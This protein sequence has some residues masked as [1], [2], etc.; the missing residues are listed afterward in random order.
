MLSD[1]VKM[2]ARRAPNRALLRADGLSDEDFKK[3]FIA[4]ANSYNNI[5]PGHI[6][7]NEL[8]EQ[9]KK[10]IKDAGGYPFEYGVPGICDGIIMGHGGM[11]YSLASRET[12]ADC[13][14]LMTHAHCF[15]GWVGVT[16][17]DKITPAMLMAAARINIPTIILTG[18]PM[19]AGTLD[20]KQYDLIS[21]FE[22]VGQYSL[23]K[24]KEHE[25]IQIEKNCCPG[26]GSCAGLFTANTMA[27]M[28]EALGMSITGSATTLAISEKKKEQ[29]YETGRQIVKL[30][31]ENLTPGDIMT[32]DAF[33]NAIIV[34]MAIGGSTNT[35]L[36]LPSIAKELNINL[37]LDTFNRIA[38]TTPNICS[39]RPGGSY[40]MK[41]LDTAG[42]IPAVLNRLKDRLK[43]SKTVNLKSIAEIAHE[44]QV[45]DPEI[46][47]PPDNPY[48]KEGGIAVLKGNIAKGGSVIKQTAVDEDMLMHTGPARVF[49]DEDTLMKAILGNKIRE[50]DVV[51]IRY[52]GKA[53]AP[54]MPEM[55]SPTSAIMGAGYRKV[56]LITDG[57]FSGGTRG[58]C[59]GHV[60]PEAYSGGEIAA[61]E[62]GDRIEINIPERTL[63]A[64]LTDERIRER[65]KKA[66]IPKRVMTPFL[67]QYRERQLS[68]SR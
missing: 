15:D 62:D 57:R 25:L 37:T 6:H 60:E 10:G 9:V 32:K 55:L 12:I 17:C 52:Q 65:M 47:R 54:G 41:D 44:S 31:K 61:V 56:V 45:F 3:P 19:D 4:I 68:M 40:F 36:H 42:G 18:G 24:I 63:N 11:R 51:I 35:T 16:N 26:A 46:I 23:G 48:H 53:G 21:A 49:E 28:T 38:K 33:Q 5:I 7:L 27:C 39:I 22:A 30:V 29:A 43:D 13:I 50:G 8:K 66:S 67:K 14:E 64:R 2:G 1:T 58:P 34:D 20:N 59:I